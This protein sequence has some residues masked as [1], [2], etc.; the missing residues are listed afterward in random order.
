MDVFFSLYV[1]Q[2]TGAYISQL[3]VQVNSVAKILTKQ[4]AQQ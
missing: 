1:E 4:C 2:I 3:P